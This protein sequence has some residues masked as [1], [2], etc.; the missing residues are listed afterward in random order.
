MKNFYAGIGSRETPE[1]VQF[2]MT[3]VASMME[4]KGWVLRSGGADG[5]DSAFEKGVLDRFNMEVYLPGSFFNGKTSRNRGYVDTTSL[6]AYGKAL[7]TVSQFH[8]APTRLTEF[9]NKLMARNAMQ[10]LGPD[11]ETP[12][13]A[14]IAWTHGGEVKGGTGQALRIANHFGTPVYNLGQP[15]TLKTFRDWVSGGLE[16]DFVLH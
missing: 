13:K 2:I 11:L 1:S 14:I 15:E 16:P 3:T 12:S 9:S 10:V 6:P 5:A 7:S 8:P 4:A